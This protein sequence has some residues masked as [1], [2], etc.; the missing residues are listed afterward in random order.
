MLGSPFPK[1]HRL[2]ANL[3]AAALGGFVLPACSLDFDQFA[4]PPEEQIVELDSATPQTD[5]GTADAGGDGG[6]SPADLG[7][8]ETDQD[9]D[10][11]PDA[12][13][14]CPEFA[15]ADQADADADEIGDLCD[16]DRDGD[17]VA[18]DVDNCAEIINPDQ[19]D[20]DRDGLGD[21]C[22]DDADGDGLTVDE[23]LAAGTNPRLS[24]SDGDGFPD[25]DDTCPVAADRVGQDADGDG[26]GDACDNDDDADTIADWRDNCPS[27]ANPDQADSDGD[28]R[29]DACADD[30]DGD[31]V[32]DGVD[33]CPLIPN[34]DQAITPCQ[35]RFESF[36]YTRATNDVFIDG[37]TVIAATDGGALII[38]AGDVLRLDTSAGLLSNRLL[39]VTVDAD[40]RRFFVSEGG[41][42]LQRPDGSIATIP[43]GDGP[44]G[45]LRDVATVNGQLW[46][47]SDVGLNLLVPDGE[48]DLFGEG[49]LPSADAR[50]LMVD[51]LDRLWV[52][53]ATQVARL[54]NGVRDDA[55]L[56]LLP[57]MGGWVDVVDAGEGNTWLLGEQGALMV[58]PDDQLVPGTLLEGLSARGVAPDGD[59]YYF[60]T[61]AGP[62]RLDAYGRLFPP[63]PALFPS[64]D[65]RVMAGSGES[66]WLG[67]VNGLVET[68]GSLVTLD[69]ALI[70]GNCANVSL[71]VD[72]ALWIGT[73]TQGLRMQAPDGAFTPVAPGALPGQAVKVIEPI[74]D[75]IWVGTDGGIGILDRTGQPLRTMVPGD[76]FPAGNVV[77]IVEGRPNEVW[78]GIEGGGVVRLDVEGTLTRFNVADSG[79]NYLS[80]QTTG[81][82]HDG[83]RLFIGTRIGLVIFREEGQRFENPVTSQG[84]NLPDVNISDV[85]VADGVVH[86]ATPGGVAVRAAA[87]GTW[88][89]LRRQ[90]G[91]LPTQT[92][93][94]RASSLAYDGEY[95]WIMMEAKANEQ[96]N[97]SI[98]RRRMGAPVEDRSS[99]RLF[100]SDRGLPASSGGRELTFGDGEVMASWCGDEQ[101]PGGVAIFDGRAL[102]KQDLSTQGLPGVGVDAVLT[103]GPGGMPLFAVEVPGVGAK[104]FSVQPGGVFAPIEPPR[105]I[106]VDRWAANTCAA[107]P[108][109]GEEGE[110]LWCIFDDFGI[111]RRGGDNRNP[112]TLITF[113][114]L[115]IGVL[116]DLAPV[117]ATDAWLAS[118]T[119]L[120]SLRAGGPR[121]LNK[122]ASNGG[123]PSDDTRAVVV[124]DAGKA[125]VATAEGVGITWL[126]GETYVWDPP[127]VAGE[128]GLSNADCRALAFT[129]DGALW[130]GTV[131][132]LFRRS[133][134][135]VITAYD[136]GSGLPLTTINAL[137][138]HPDGRL[139]VATDAG[140][141]IGDGE[142]PFELLGQVDG[143]PG[144]A[145]HDVVT[146][147][148]AVWVLGDDGIAQLRP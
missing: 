124:D 15:N 107:V 43:V 144:T 87:D 52:A 39:S 12:E 93:T 112:W 137:A 111:A 62:Q 96:P 136:T 45:V 114:Q 134:D 110:V 10:G 16:D 78:M 147:G 106:G 24:D 8:V 69:A 121:T 66:R 142:G 123:L 103:V 38:N 17:T 92:R 97:G 122:A 125:Y 148:G 126:D 26:L 70:G 21:A 116:R 61:A 108:A 85:L 133:A 88:T 60:A 117:S 105:Q 127:I 145:A 6:G 101:T 25:G 57:D 140:L 27:T 20:L 53:T 9:R 80:D 36:T 102:I 13:D 54:N 28:G 33:V 94:D 113:E 41:L 7:L 3:L 115:R 31:G 73:D 76:R 100:T 77:A 42:S 23:E 44:Q 2:L 14:N 19:V 18:N 143:L 5:V 32:L 75:E 48:W 65:T 46:V 72:D 128:G 130:I 63:A 64:P 22:D 55:A 98:V 81:L 135:G 83:S 99:L 59:G 104:M 109:E 50:G 79:P 89:T 35:P 90:S 1:S 141:S 138:A 30:A 40:G 120:V 139:L 68:D 146:V 47:S 129:Q 11:V 131:D 71:R 84:G 91:G 86:V 49:A 119:G 56:A 51:D 34:P 58:G 4:D 67:T 37:Q 132:G 95:I 82:G 118:D 74:G 29:G